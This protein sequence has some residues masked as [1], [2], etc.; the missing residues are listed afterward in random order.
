MITQIPNCMNGAR[1]LLSREDSWLHSAGWL[2]CVIKRTRR[3]R[4]T[5]THSLTYTHTQLAIDAPLEYILNL[6][7]TKLSVIQI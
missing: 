6:T 2:I 1:T 3:R 4:R 5:H 7:H